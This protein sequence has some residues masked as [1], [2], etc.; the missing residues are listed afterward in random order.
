MPTPIDITVTH[1]NR[2]PTGHLHF[3][4]LTRV[5]QVNLLW[6]MAECADVRIFNSQL[7]PARISIFD[8][9]Q[10]AEMFKFRWCRQ[11]EFMNQLNLT[12]KILT[13]MLH[14][15]NI[16][17]VFLDNFRSRLQNSGAV[18]IWTKSWWWCRICN[19]KHSVSFTF[20]IL[21]FI[22][23]T[24]VGTIAMSFAHKKSR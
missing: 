7:L 20:P 14:I 2:P 10:E 13:R 9:N 22:E 6:R 8:Q 15:T 11:S 18:D 24:K 23:N 21:F 12:S 5:I 4:I 16:N 3:R 17:F 19:K 1:C